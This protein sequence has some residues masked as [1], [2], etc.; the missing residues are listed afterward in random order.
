MELHTSDCA[1][2]SGINMPL[3]KIEKDM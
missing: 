2:L 1:H 3:S